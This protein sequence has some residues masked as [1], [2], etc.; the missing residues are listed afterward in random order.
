MKYTLAARQ[1]AA[2]D[3]AHAGVYLAA[4]ERLAGWWDAHEGAA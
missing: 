1:A 4:A 2:T 3:P